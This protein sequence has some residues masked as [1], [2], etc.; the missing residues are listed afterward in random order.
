MEIKRSKMLATGCFLLTGLFLIGF[1]STVLHAAGST[2]PDKPITL[3]IPFTPGG[4]VDL[5]GRILAEAMEKHLKQPVVVVNKPGASATIGGYALA[6]AKPDG[7]TLGFLPASGCV[8]EVFSFF[9]SAP[10]SS[11]DLRP[12]CP[13]TILTQTITVKEDAPWSNL[14]EL[15]EFARKNPG[16][17]YGHN[18]RNLLQYVAVAT[19]ARAEK[20]TLVDVAFEGDAK[21]VPA[22]LGG[23]ISIITP[24]FTSIK[25]LLAAKK[26]RA[27]AVLNQ[28]RPDF[29]PDIPTLRELGYKVP[30]AAY[31]AFSAP[32][33]T[34]DEIVNKLYE[35]V[36]K[37]RKDKDFQNKNRKIDLLVSDEDPASYEKS[38]IELKES[39]QTFFTEE[40]MVKK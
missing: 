18:G 39:L 9:F 15:V 23:H 17:K 20:V 11:H 28:T 19:I 35:V 29:L 25:S 30:H 38:R 12:I 33:G 40:G 31:T 1:G 7:Y 3:I 4:A 14:K 34:P 36:D 2:Y 26:V 16:L 21:Q 22:L 32:R 37:I 5:S 24:A 10:Y 8:P 13:V 6:S 27:L